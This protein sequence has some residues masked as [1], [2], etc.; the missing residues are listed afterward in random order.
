MSTETTQPREF[1]KH[2]KR[3]VAIDA[4][5]HIRRL[6]NYASAMLACELLEMLR[7]RLAPEFRETADAAYQEA[8]LLCEHAAQSFT[9]FQEWGEAV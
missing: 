8:E 1:F 6:D 4:V 9:D 5:W 7:Q 3:M 2:T